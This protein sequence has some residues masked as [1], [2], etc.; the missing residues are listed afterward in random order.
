MSE[1]I[2]KGLKV[3]EKENK[4]D[5]NMIKK[6]SYITKINKTQK[7]MQILFQEI[8]RNL[9]ITFQKDN[10]SINYEEYYF[11]GIPQPKNIELY[12]ISEDSVNIKWKIDDLNILEMDKKQI[13]FI[14]EMKKENKKFIKKYEGK[15]NFCKIDNLKE[16]Q[17]YEFRICVLY[18]NVMGN[19]SEIK[20]IKTLKMCDSVILSESNKN[21]EFVKKLLEWSGYKAMKLLYRGT[22]DGAFAK[23]F[24]EKCDNQGPTITLC[25]NK[26]GYIFGGYSSNAWKSEGGYCTSP[27]SFL[28]SLTN[29]FGTEPIKFPLIDNNSNKS[30]YNNGSYMPTFGN[31]HDLNIRDNFID[32][33][34][35]IYFTYTYKDTLGKGRAVFTGNINDNDLSDGYKYS[36]IKEVEVFK[37]L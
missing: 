3:F 28:F 24:H 9:K 33:N 10:N 8:M 20:K 18:N 12:D 16:N 19:W 27:N 36:K 1:K 14:V 15:E 30:I 25:K 2:N 29:I 31:G 23:N 11:N 5:K 35:Q 17:N 34:A 37:L 7:D 21:N 22:K 6:L 13:I 32:N 26:E 4:E